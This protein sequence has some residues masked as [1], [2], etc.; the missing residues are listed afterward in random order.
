MTWAPW[1]LPGR[2]A[3]A[4]ASSI[5]MLSHRRAHAT[6]GGPRAQLKSQASSM[7][8]VQHSRRASWLA[9]VA[10]LA[11]LLLSRWSFHAFGLAHGH[12]SMWVAKVAVISHTL[13]FTLLALVTSKRDKGMGFG[14]LTLMGFASFLEVLTFGVLHRLSSMAHGSIYT[15]SLAG[16]VVPYIMV[17]SSVLM[18]K[19]YQ[20]FTWLGSI[21]VGVGLLCSMPFATHPADLPLILLGSAALCL[22]GL[23]LITK[24]MLLRGSM[25]S[26]G[27]TSMSVASVAAL[28]SVSQLAGLMLPVQIHNPAGAVAS[29]AAIAAKIPSL[30]GIALYSLAS[31]LVRFTMIRTL[32][33]TSALSISLVNVLAISLT[34]ALFSTWEVRVGLGTTLLGIAMCAAGRERSALK[35]EQQVHSKSGLDYTYPQDGAWVPQNS[36]KKVDALNPKVVPFKTRGSGEEAIKLRETQLKSNTDFVVLASTGLVT[37]SAEMDIVESLGAVGSALVPFLLVVGA[38]TAAWYSQNVPFYFQVMP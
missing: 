17:L 16:M 21:I 34:P 23:G 2:A 22:P 26:G 38:G 37:S 15:L 14:K 9:P 8:T 5:W 28:T 13:V 20:L 6:S 24:E 19:R 4:M 25:S 11:T 18:R 33:E 32:R 10:Y 36:S 7:D 30:S 27:R 31:G 3:A 12:A 35:Q 1:L 29:T